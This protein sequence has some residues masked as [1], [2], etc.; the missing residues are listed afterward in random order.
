MDAII[1]QTG[2]GNKEPESYDAVV[3]AQGQQKQQGLNLME[4]LMQ[5]TGSS[6]GATSPGIENVQMRQAERRQNPDSKTGTVLKFLK[7][8]GGG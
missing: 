8:M 6:V 1:G 7:L 2:V 4:M 5:P 3:Q